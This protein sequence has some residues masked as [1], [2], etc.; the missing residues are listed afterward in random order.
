[1]TAEEIIKTLKKRM[2]NG[3]V[4]TVMFSYGY[5]NKIG[6]FYVNPTIKSSLKKEV[7]T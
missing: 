4:I 1:M 7:T 3:E 6:N 2:S 5:H